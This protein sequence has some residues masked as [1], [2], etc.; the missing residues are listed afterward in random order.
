MRPQPKWLSVQMTWSTMC[1]MLSFGSTSILSDEHSML[2][3]SRL[4]FA[5]ESRPTKLETK[6]LLR[7]TNPLSG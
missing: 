1:E 6:G 5:R 4:E 2:L 7:R 3:M